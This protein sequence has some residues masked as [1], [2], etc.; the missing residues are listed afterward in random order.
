M[1]NKVWLVGAGPGDPELLTLKAVRVLAQADVVL[2]DDLVHREVLVHCPTARIISVGKRGGCRST[3][4][5]FILRL[6]LRYAR[7]GFFVVRLKGGDPYIF[8]RGGEEVAWLAERGIDCQVVGGMTSGLVAA[9]SAGIALTARGSVRGVTLMTA[10]TADGSQ[11]DWQ[12]LVNSRTTLVFYMGVN[13]LRQTQQNLLAAGMPATMPVAM[14]EHASY[15]YQRQTR[16]SLGSLADDADRFALRSPAI[17]IIGS[18][19]AM[20]RSMVPTGINSAA[21]D[22]DGARV[23]S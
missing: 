5:D 2:I 16:S 18:V 6:M 22:H 13:T 21:Q 17:L 12:A 15:A 1:T 19:A 8:G 23:A 14:I 10:H 4:Q 3:P 7:Q 9:A 20:C 11:P